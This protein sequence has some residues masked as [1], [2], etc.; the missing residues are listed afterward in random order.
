MEIR[1]A[2]EDEE[3][4]RNSAEREFGQSREGNA[5]GLSLRMHWHHVQNS[6]FNGILTFFKTSNLVSFTTLLATKFK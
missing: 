5:M 1:K 6:G 4:D 3:E 2:F